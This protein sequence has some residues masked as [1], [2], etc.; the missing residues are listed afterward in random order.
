MI[1]PNWLPNDWNF[2]IPLDECHS[3]VLDVDISKKK[4][5]PGITMQEWNQFDCFLLRVFLGDDHLHYVDHILGLGLERQ[6]G[7]GTIL[8]GFNN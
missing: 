4:I 1:K 6:L 5:F 8:E 2:L 3:R 7:T